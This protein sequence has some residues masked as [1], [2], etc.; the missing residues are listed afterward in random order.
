VPVRFAFRRIASIRPEVFAA[1]SSAVLLPVFSPQVSALSL[2][3]FAPAQVSPPQQVR[4]ASQEQASQALPLLEEVCAAP[5]ARPAQQ[6]ADAPPEWAESG[7]AQAERLP[8]ASVPD[9][10]VPDDCSAALVPDDHSAESLPDD[11][12]AVSAQADSVAWPDESVEPA[13][14]VQPRQAARSEQVDSPADSLVDSRVLQA[15]RVASA[16]WPP[17]APCSASPVS[18][19]ARPSPWV[20]PPQKPPDAASALHF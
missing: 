20:E 6:F 12:P 11:C 9:A 19:Q 2:A 3:A 18:P 10:S 15:G 16:R 8:A 14:P 1:P 17:D 5:V 4:Q 7:S 13:R